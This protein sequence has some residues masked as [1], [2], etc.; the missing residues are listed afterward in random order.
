MG[1]APVNGRALPV[2][3]KVGWLLTITDF[4]PVQIVGFAIYVISAPFLVL[5]ALL[6]RSEMAEALAKNPAV[7]ESRSNWSPLPL[8]TTAFIAWF[9]VYGE[10]ASIRPVSVGVVLSGLVLLLFTYR[11]LQRTKPVTML[12][13]T[14]LQNIERITAAAKGGEA[15]EKKKPTSKRSEASVHLKIYGWLHDQAVLL[16]ACI[17]GRQGRDRV[18]M[19]V[20]VEYMLFLL[21][22][23]IA[24][25][26]FWA[27]V[28][29]AATAPHYVPL[30]TLFYFSAS[31]FLPGISPPTLLSSLPLWVQAG[32]AATAW[33]LFVIF[34]G[35]AA[36][37]VPIRQTAYA[38]R[39]AATYV[40]CRRNVLSSSA[41]LRKMKKLKQTL[42]S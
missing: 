38:T 14:I 11:A 30:E 29:K 13:A 5:F 26:L 4:N 33:V 20:L 36:S 34:V 15:N 22:L 16:T 8:C 31:H 24:A 17:R 42:P 25:I 12:D 32:P 2:V 1:F 10:A 28:A 40:I 23:A 37:I 27:L 41:Y 3:L 18:Y 35:P 7:T 39:L 9:I 6:F 21:L 19:F